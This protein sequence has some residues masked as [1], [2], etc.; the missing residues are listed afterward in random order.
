MFPHVEAIDAKRAGKLTGMLL[1]MGPALVD[2]LLS[3]PALIPGKVLEAQ[4]V[5]DAAATA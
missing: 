3:S 2:A 4:A 5:L 1:S